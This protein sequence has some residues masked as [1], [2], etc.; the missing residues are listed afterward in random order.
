MRFIQYLLLLAGLI[1]V[2]LCSLSTIMVVG[3][4]KDD[5]NLPLTAQIATLSGILAIALFAGAI[6]AVAGRPP[7][8]VH[9]GAP[10]S[11]LG[12]H[13]P[14]PAQQYPAAPYTQQ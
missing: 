7:V 12:G 9:Q 14:Q 8:V 1:S 10:W 11:Q 5:S 3:M 2:A 4:N 13:T 6:A